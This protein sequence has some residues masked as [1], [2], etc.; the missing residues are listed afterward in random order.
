MAPETDPEPTNAPDGPE[1]AGAIVPPRNADG[2]P[3]RPASD[4][5]KEA[6]LT[7]EAVEAI[8]TEVEAGDE[9]PQP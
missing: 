7:D 5:A 3:G 8:E 4:P 2:T 6:A 1:P 9:I